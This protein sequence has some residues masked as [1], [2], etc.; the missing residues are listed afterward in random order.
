MIITSMLG[1]A[2]VA[3]S[4]VFMRGL[5]PPQF[6]RA[7]SV[8]ILM[9]LWRATDFFTRLPDQVFQG[10]GRTGTFTWTAILEHASR[11]ALL[12]IL[13]GRFGFNGVFYAFM[14]SSILRAIVAWPLM[15][16]LVAWP[17]LSVWQT[18]INPSVAA[19]ANYLVLRWLAAAVW[20]GPGHIG[21]AWLVILGSLFGSLPIYMFV[22]GL[23]GWDDFSLEE[24]RDAAELV[25]APFG[26]I[27]RMA[28]R[29]VAIG[30]SLSPLH[31]RFPGNL[32]LEAAD[33]AARLTALKADLR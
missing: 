4:D 17:S 14:I 7:A 5:L 9:H 1:G 13:I 8:M 12:W 10:V 2:F 30:S 25:P 15:G 26:A 31:N 29:L 22:S 27:A 18:L 21:S 20:Q 28:H 6:A 33:E 3:F 11:V 23:L 16:L 32:T 24:F 19:V